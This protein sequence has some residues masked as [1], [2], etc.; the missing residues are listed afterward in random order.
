MGSNAG[1]VAGSAGGGNGSGSGGNGGSGSGGGAGGNNSGSTGGNT[2]G[3]GGGDGGGGGGIPDAGVPTPT[4]CNVGGVN[5][6]PDILVGYSPANGQSVGA[7]GQ[8]KVWVT[9]EGAPIIAPGEVVDP[10]TGVI[11]TPGDRT[12]KA[13]DGY[14]WEP[15][16]YIAPQTAENG[17]TPHFPDMIKGHYN[18][19]PT[20]TW[21]AGQLVQGMDPPPAG[22]QLLDDYTGEDIWNVSSLGLSP[23]AYM[24][25]F[26]I[27][28]GDRD[29]GVG[30]VTIV[31]Q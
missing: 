17:G 12:A 8:I 24:A 20:T 29:R 5:N 21:T 23:G 9:D 14:L 16:L 30:C 26:V 31:I 27:H 28:D 19:D 11:T 10:N 15:A 4:L 1:T 22:A 13:A 3:G 7:G 25:E 18:P 6:E 2:S